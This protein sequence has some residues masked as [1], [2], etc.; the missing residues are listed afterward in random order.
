MTLITTSNTTIVRNP[1]AETA[2]AVKAPEIADAIDRVAKTSMIM[3][4]ITTP[5]GVL[6]TSIIEPERPE[7][8]PLG[9]V[10]LPS[11][12]TLKGCWKGKSG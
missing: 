1:A 10:Y 7:L 12:K 2:A 9:N 6:T 3:R 4:S 11:Q 5:R 8:P